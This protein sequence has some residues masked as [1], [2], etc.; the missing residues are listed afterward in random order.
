MDQASRVA[1]APTVA[2][3]VKD[4]TTNHA[5]ASN[6]TPSMNNLQPG[7]DSS[8]FPRIPSE[9]TLLKKDLALPNPSK[10]WERSQ[11]ALDLDPKNFRRQKSSSVDYG[12]IAGGK[13]SEHSRV[14]WD[15]SKADDSNL[16]VGQQGKFKISLQTIHQKEEMKASAG[17][18]SPSVS[19]QTRVVKRMS[20]ETSHHPTLRN[21]E[22]A[23]LEVPGFGSPPKQQGNGGGSGSAQNTPSPSASTAHAKFMFTVNQGKPNLTMVL[24]NAVPVMQEN[25]QR[26]TAQTSGEQCHALKEMLGMIEQ[27]WATPCI[28][29]DLAYGLCDVLRTDGGLE[30]LIQNCDKTKLRDIQL[31]SARVLEQSMTVG[32]REY[33]AQ[34]GLEVIANL[35]KQC[36][37]DPKM[38]KAM[39]GIL[40]SL[41]KHS[42]DTC[43]KVIKFGGLET[44]LYSCRTCD[45]SILRHC[46]E[47][48]ANLAIYGGEDNQQEMIAKKAP[49]WLFPLAFSND[50]TTRY[51]AFLAIT[52]LSANKELESAVV[53]SGTLELVEPFIRTHDPVLFANSD[54]SHIHGQSKDWLRRL[55]PLLGS[56]RSEAQALAAFHFA[57]EA[58]IKSGQ[59]KLEVSTLC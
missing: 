42:E 14:Y 38:T 6:A 57:M 4:P 15:L 27:A 19:I 8:S 50:D 48:L 31:G 20:S 40:E 7:D 32:N 16:Q 23:E 33:V 47:A 53:R 26:L 46:A 58:G 41:F 36:L 37:D 1:P 59:G 25:I 56:K 35:A 12:E 30:V 9:G 11:S 5:N 55:V 22:Y 28:G 24:A 3:T 21:V 45:T 29:R 43:T 44:I 49:E 54:K 39:T 13:V 17:S 34:R 10:P 18:S 52:T 51:F 2:A